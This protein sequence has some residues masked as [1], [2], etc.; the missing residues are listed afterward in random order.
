MIDKSLRNEG[1]GRRTHLFRLIVME[2]IKAESSDQEGIACGSARGSRWSDML[3]VGGGGG[4]VFAE[5]G[6][7]AGA[8]ALERAGAGAL[9][10]AGAGALR[11]KL[12]AESAL[13]STPEAS[14]L[15]DYL[16]SSAGRDAQAAR[17]FAVA[18]WQEVDE[19][20]KE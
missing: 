3:G 2:H 6:F 18:R 11:L 4:G 15:W 7:G 10:R 19:S 5:V 20:Q 16:R 8:G 17:N 1:Q 13:F 14:L 9:E 12:S